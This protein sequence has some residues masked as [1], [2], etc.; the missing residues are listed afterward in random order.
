M[1]IGSILVLNKLLICCRTH[2]SFSP[3]QHKKLTFELSNL[4]GVVFSF[5]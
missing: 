5:D 2:S 4:T 3:V 1:T